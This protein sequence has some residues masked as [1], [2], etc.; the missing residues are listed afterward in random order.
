MSTTDSVF[1]FLQQ[2][3]TAASGYVKFA[4]GDKKVFRILANPI[5]GWQLFVDGKPQRAKPENLSDLPTQNEKGEAPKKFV[6]FIVYEYADNGPGA[7]KVWDVPQ[8][9]IQEQLKMLYKANNEHWTA[10]EL[11]VT[12]IGSGMDTKYP[13]TGIKSPIEET[14]LAFCS[15][16]SQYVDLTKLYTSENPFIKELPPLEAKKEQE[17][18]ADDLP[19]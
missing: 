9:T 14:L 7:V 10:Y 13:V 19:F 5:Q 1:D 12:R 15:V 6:T 2:S 3:N 18:K 11:V 17:T 8:K 16:A 4:P